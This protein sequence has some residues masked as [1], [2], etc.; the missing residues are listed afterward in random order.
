MSLTTGWVIVTFLVDFIVLK[1]HGMWLYFL[2]NLVKGHV[3]NGEVVAYSNILCI[4]KKKY[5]Q[6][7]SRITN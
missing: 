6:A 2:S 1:E 4:Y 7:R 5:S 3:K